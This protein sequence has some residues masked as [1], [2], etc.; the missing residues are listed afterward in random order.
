MRRNHQVR[1]GWF[2]I[3][4]VV[5][6]SLLQTT[7]SSAA[8]AKLA[9]AEKLRWTGKYAEAMELYIKL[10]AIPESNF[11]STIALADCLVQTGQRE[12]A[13]QQLIALR[14]AHPK[15]AR[16]L[17]ELSQLQ[18]TRGDFADATTSANAA[19]KADGDSLLARW[20]LAEIARSTGDL[21]G[22][23]KSYEWFIDYYN[24]AEEITD[25]NDL[26]IIGQAASQFARWRRNSGQFTFLVNTLFPDALKLNENFWPAHVEIGRLFLEKFNQGDAARS[27]ESAFTINSN[28]ADVHVARAELALQRFGLERVKASTDRALEINPQYLPAFHLQADLAFADTRSAEAI[29]I[30]L[31]ARKLNQQ[32]HGTQ[33]RLAAAYGAVDGLRTP[34]AG[35]RMGQIVDAVT[36]E[37][38]KCGEFFY[39]MAQSFDGLRK[40][41]AAA[42][43]YQEANRRMPQLLGPR[44]KL[45]LMYMRL[46]RETEAAE[47]LKEAFE[48][49]PFNVRVKNMLAVLDVLEGYAVLETEH[50]I[51]KFDRGQDEI[52]AKAAAKYLEEDVY[53][54]I[55]EKLGYAPR[56]KSLFEFFNRAKNT[57]GHGWFSARMVGLPYIGTVGACAGKMVAMAS[58]DSMPQSFNWARVLKHEF[59]HVVNLQQTDY[60][61]PHWFTEALAVWHEQTPR[62]A[63]WIK[64]LAQRQQ[65]GT[66]LNLDNI[67]H[68]FI[69]PSSSD[70][71]TLAYCQAELY[72]EYMLETYGEDSLAKMLAA[73]A[74]HLTTRDALQRCFDVEQDK[75]EAGY[76]RFVND[77]HK[78]QPAIARAKFRTLRELQKAIEKDP[79]DADALAD[80]AYAYLARK[81]LPTARRMAERAL[82]IKPKHQLATYVK[83]RLLISIGDVRPAWE[84]LKAALDRDA[85]HEKLLGLLAG[86]NLKA[87]KYEEAADLYHLGAKHS[88]HP[89]KWLKALSQVYIASKNEEELVK[90]LADLAHQERDNAIIRKKLAEMALNSEDFDQAGRWANQALQVTVKDSSLYSLLARASSGKEKH[91]V[92]ADYW[93]T[94][95]LLEPRRPAWRLELADAYISAKDHP[96]ARRVL[97]DLLSRDSDYPGARQL[98]EKLK[99]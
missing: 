49:D 60:N 55:V 26:L 31:E 68:G 30:L 3:F 43:Y 42:Q 32:D 82:K 92:A 39:V 47:F 57:G 81:S 91:A 40:F 38:G 45:G 99:P 76:T 84:L 62:P 17:A 46:G 63:E 19:L 25:P 85:P 74:D 59:V 6:M 4:V 50:F 35:S 86:I 16:V 54:E 96:A 29:E 95:V 8:D 20:I 5:L 18:Y 27:F 77:L 37:N 11:A 90:T 52:L 1:P 15:S 87:K 33:G 21:K 97:E 53:P 64:V 44:A 7:P 66:L 24:A 61:I 36:D 70:E 75:F 69:R 80:I 78:Q 12:K 9:D 51:I 89:T 23:D 10:Q 67:N 72:A 48:L 73:Y 34:L 13:E 71:W 58:P 14:K 41:P 28:C 98:L 93:E 88:P 22:A 65:A 2:V 94:A 79:Q 56:D 83:A